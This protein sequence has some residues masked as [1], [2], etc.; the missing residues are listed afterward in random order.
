MSG[1]RRY[2]NLSLSKEGIKKHTAIMKLKNQCKKKIKSQLR[3]NELSTVE[4]GLIYLT[5]AMEK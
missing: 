4:N 3:E 1:D 2:I 5:Q